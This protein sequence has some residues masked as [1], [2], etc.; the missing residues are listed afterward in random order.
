MQNNSPDPRTIDRRSFV[1]TSLI[2]AAIP[3]A[4]ALVRSSA[5]AVERQSGPETSLPEI[6]DCNVHLFDWHQLR[7]SLVRRCSTGFRVHGTP[8]EYST[9]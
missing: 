2:P 7:S 1:K 3:L 9:S 6:I 4:A 5:P 8:A